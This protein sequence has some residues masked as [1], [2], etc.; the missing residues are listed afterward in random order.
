MGC[1]VLACLDSDV[2][3]ADEPDLELGSATVAARPVDVKGMC[4]TGPGDERDAYWRQLAEVCNTPYERLPHVLTTVDRVRVKAS[5]NGGFVVAR[6]EAKV[7]QRTEEFFVRSARARLR[8]WGA[9]IS[10]RAGHGMVEGEGAQYWG[11]A[12]ACLSLAAWGEGGSVRELPP[13]HNFPAHLDVWV[14]EAGMCRP[15][16]A[17]HYHHLFETPEGAMVRHRLNLPKHVKDWLDLRL[18]LSA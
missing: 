1:G 4:T 3:F 18:P 2:F 16:V 17:V 11:S 5:Y 6:A 10:V 9:G 12:Q 7:F 8:P 13:T 14:S 15:L